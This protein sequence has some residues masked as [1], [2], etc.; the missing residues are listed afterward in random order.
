VGQ[1]WTGLTERMSVGHG[2]WLGWR[3]LLLL[4][5]ALQAGQCGWRGGR[6]QTGTRRPDSSPACLPARADVPR[7][8]Q[9]PSRRAHHLGGV[10]RH[11]ASG[12]GAAGPDRGLAAWG[13][14]AAP[15][16]PSATAWPLQPRRVHFVVCRFPVSAAGSGAPRAQ[17][18]PLSPPRSSNASLHLFSHTCMPLL[19][20][21]QVH[22]HVESMEE[23]IK[24][25]GGLNGKPAS[26]YNFLH[27]RM[28][29]DW[30]EHCK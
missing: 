19:S 27:L 4:S 29:N 20:A 26:R 3:W 11:A 8:A 14:R 15:S 5:E 30:V 7:R 18:C 13:L 2:G 12:A 9:P 16:S 25:A 1:S 24:R 28:E 10:G 23:A 22:A 6:M 17:A 21:C